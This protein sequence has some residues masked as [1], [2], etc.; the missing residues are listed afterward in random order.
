MWMLYIDT[1]VHHTHILKGKLRKKGVLDHPFINMDTIYKFN[2]HVF[3][4]SYTQHLS[5][6]LDTE[7]Y[8]SM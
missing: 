5:F 7:K 2:F 1:L 4:S 8:E 3:Q 6:K